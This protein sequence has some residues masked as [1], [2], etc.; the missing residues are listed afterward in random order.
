MKRIQTIA[1]YLGSKC[2]N[3]PDFV[4]LANKIGTL[5]AENGIG[6]VYGGTNIGTMTAM[7]DGVRAAGGKLT[8]VIP[9]IFVSK[10]FTYGNL[11]NCVKTQNL[12]E[13]KAKM[14]EL[15]QA[16]LV[17]P[18]SYGTMDEV[19]EYA[20]NN[21]LCK[22]ERPI[23]ILNHKGFYDPLLRQLDVMEEYGF[24]TTEL[25]GMFIPCACVEDVISKI[26]SIN[27]LFYGDH[28]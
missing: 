23:F 5:L 17:L 19:F 11:T 26:L 13:R 20:V 16:A 6:V 12:K 27:Q 4:E 28:Y 2:G 7:A 3:T 21:Q 24:L 9:E 25:K 1:V 8:G 22:L 10:S 15:S 18:G 14:E